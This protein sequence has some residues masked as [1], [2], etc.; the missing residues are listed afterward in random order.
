MGQKNQKIRVTIISGLICIAA[1]VLGIIFGYY[2]DFDWIHNSLSYL[3]ITGVIFNIGLVVS[4]LA[5][6][7]FIV[8]VL[9]F[10]P[11]H[12]RSFSWTLLLLSS[13]LL[14]AIGIFPM[15]TP[16]NIHIFITIAFLLCFA[17]ALI[18]I[19]KE[20]KEDQPAAAKFTELCVLPFVLV[21][22]AFLCLRFFFYLGMAVPELISLVIAMVWIFGFVYK[23]IKK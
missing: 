23:Y 6:G 1:F 21:W 5:L 13:A 19:S 22:L 4:G 18:L 11:R 15:Q 14:S 9:D 10:F 20:I 16:F 12:R 7:S 2:P 8:N 17:L 3:G